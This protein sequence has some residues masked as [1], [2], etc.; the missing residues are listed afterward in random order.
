[1]RSAPPRR[2]PLLLGLALI[3]ILAP[4]APLMAA[5]EAEAD[6]IVS[7]A[8]TFEE[9]DPPSTLAVPTTEVR[10]ARFPFVDIH[11]H[12]WS[13]PT[14][15]LS[16]TVAEMDALNMAVM[17]NLSGRL[18]DSE[19]HLHACIENGRQ[20]APGRFLVFTNLSYTGIDEAGWG[21]AMAERVAEDVAAGAAGLKIYKS[22]GLRVFDG[23]GERVAVDDPR[24]D[25]I[26]ARCGELGVPV[27]IHSG[28]PS[29]FWKPWD[30]LNERWLELKQKPERRREPGSDPSFEQVMGE[31]L[32]VFEKHPGTTFI[33]A[34]LAWMGHDLAALGKLL[35]DHPNMYTEI[36]AVIAELG[37]QPRFARQWFIDHKDRVI[38][39]KDVWTPEEYWCYFRVLETADEYFDYYRRRHAF[40]KMYGLELPDDVLRKLYYGNALDL[41]PQL[42]RSLFPDS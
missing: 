25:P 16:T 33:S 19:E 28:D 18:R 27:L 15:D 4:G 40:W 35:D 38:F 14:D 34:H 6:P 41:F 31:Q 5:Q 21:E 37:R 9:Y 42:D 26:W 24:L 39:G 32:H 11:N 36:G 29:P 2:L 30:N 22:L 10:R 7:D 3:M 23:S 20:N 17:V 12:Q 1:V 8:L 13:M